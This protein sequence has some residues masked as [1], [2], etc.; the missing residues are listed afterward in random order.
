MITTLSGWLLGLALGMRHALEPDHLTAVS[1]L[2]VENR[3]A[4]R[5]AWLGVFW[6]LGHS[7]A[8]LGV[9]LCL[10]LLNA[11]MPPRV[12]NGFE[13]CVAVMLIALGV[14]S[15]RRAM[16]QGSTG[17]EREH[18]H[19]IDSHTHPVVV[20][21]VHVGR[22]TFA[23]RSLVVGV[24]HGLAGSGALT[25]LVLAGLPS[26]AARLAYLFV[27]GLGSVL[28]MAAISGL[29]GWPLAQLGRNPR[30]GRGVMFATGAWSTL[31]GFMWGVPLL[32]KF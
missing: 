23:T 19:G 25:V 10:A 3:S 2:V 27:F 4:S 8:L 21:H 6:G 29:A 22:W 14:R 15:I 5:G 1:T 32:G 7:L 31:L 24:V 16:R 13:L 28:G 11:Q 20:P 18:T 30:V 17:A 26:M 9:G 12:A